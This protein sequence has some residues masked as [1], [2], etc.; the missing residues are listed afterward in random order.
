[1]AAGVVFAGQANAIVT[2]PDDPPPTEPV[3][4]SLISNVSAQCLDL[5]DIQLGRGGVWATRQC[6]GSSTMK[7]Q[8]IYDSG[9][10]S[11]RN[12]ADHNCAEMFTNSRGPRV[13]GN[14]C[15]GRLSER[16]TPVPQPNGSTQ[17]RSQYNGLCLSPVGLVENVAVVG[18]RPCGEPGTYWFLG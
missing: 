7:F 10:A 12:V 14:S 2:P 8:T 3:K 5:Y 17:W 11:I 18:G 16:W 4:W 9:F 1:M 6:T 13:Y 15:D